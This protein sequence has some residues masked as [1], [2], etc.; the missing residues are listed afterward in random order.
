[1]LSTNYFPP[2]VLIQG[3][4]KKW[5]H[6]VFNNIAIEVMAAEVFIEINRKAQ[7]IHMLIEP[8]A[9]FGNP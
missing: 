7:I 3:F 1:M 4:S 8:L 5:E 6:T 2:P 9:A